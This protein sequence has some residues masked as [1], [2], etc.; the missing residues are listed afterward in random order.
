MKLIRYFTSIFVNLHPTTSILGAN[1]F[2]AHQVVQRLL[3]EAAL[4][5]FSPHDGQL[6]RPLIQ[7]RIRYVQ[8]TTTNTL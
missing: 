5:Q 2:L 4:V 3:V 8:L 6:R 1:L 7:R